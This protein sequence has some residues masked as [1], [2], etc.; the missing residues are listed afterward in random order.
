VAMY[1]VICA[2]S[3]LVTIA[4]IRALIGRSSA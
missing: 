4:D 1:A 2:K 3:R